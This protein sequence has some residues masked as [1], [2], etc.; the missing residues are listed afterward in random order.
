MKFNLTTPR[1]RQSR[2]A[3][4]ETA[5]KLFIEKGYRAVST[6][7]IAEAA[8]V[9]LGAI[10]YH[11]GSKAGLFNETVRQMMRESGCT[12]LGITLGLAQ[13][14]SRAEAALSLCSFIRSFMEYQLRPVGPQACKLMF[15]EV[16]GDSSEEPEMFES[17]LDLVVT[18]FV[19]PMNASL[20][21]VVG[22]IAPDAD[23][24]SLICICRSIVAQCVFYVTHRPVI[25]RIEGQDISTTPVFERTVDH[26]CR[27]TLRGLGCDE[28]L[29]DRAV[30]L[31]QE[32]VISHRVH[33]K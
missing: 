19:K 9:N 26:L 15:R 12:E 24:Q 13:P 33:S 31:S 21:A 27:F 16:L 25:E 4:L 20:S 10:Q 14:S 2:Q 5:E 28:A 29:I 17:L 32:S 23:A 6:R 8:K 1:K 7:D 11:F 30:A 22:L 3:L 18:E